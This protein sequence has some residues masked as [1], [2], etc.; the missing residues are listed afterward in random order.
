MELLHILWDFYIYHWIATYIIGLLHILWDCYIYYWIATYLLGLLHI[1]WDCCTYYGI[2]TYI[3][4]LDAVA[5]S[6]ESRLPVWQSS[7]V[8]STQ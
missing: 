2:A 6:V 8:E 5:E 1:L 7:R 4:G 3:G